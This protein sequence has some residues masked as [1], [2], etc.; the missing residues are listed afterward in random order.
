MPMAA[1]AMS[2]STPPCSVPIG[3]A[4]RSVASNSTTARP[5]ST[6][7]RLKPRS[8]AIGGG[9]TS[10]RI[11]CPRTSSILAMRPPPAATLDRGQER[12]AEEHERER[13]DDRQ[14][15]RS[16]AEPVDDQRAADGGQRQPH[17]PGDERPQ[18]PPGALRGE[19][20][21]EPEAEEPV[22]RPHHAQVGAAGGDDG[23]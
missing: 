15:A 23:G 7:A 16:A 17:E 10:P 12:D 8:V 14:R 11:S 13:D 2:A 22:A 18:H 9:G 21:R 3:L 4:W 5:G 1:S 6:D 20:Q 19:V